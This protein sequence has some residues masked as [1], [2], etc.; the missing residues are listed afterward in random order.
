MATGAA[1]LTA[2]LLGRFFLPF[3]PGA[4]IQ[5]QISAIGDNVGG[6]SRHDAEDHESD[7]ANHAEDETALALLSKVVSG[8]H[9]ETNP[10]P[11]HAVITPQTLHAHRSPGTGF[12]Q[13][14][15]SA[16]HAN[17]HR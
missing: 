2:L 9:G 6:A 5:D 8:E 13:L 17:S 4:R 11:I 12:Q 15:I 14:K 1:G 3:P 10:N 16:A 7:V